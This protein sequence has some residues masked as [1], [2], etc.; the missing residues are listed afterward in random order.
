MSAMTSMK[1]KIVR[2]RVEEGKTGLFYATSPDLK[3]LLVAE[4]DIDT[5]DVAVSTAI[6]SLYEACGEKV[7]VTKAQDGDPQFFPWVAIPAEVAEKVM[8]PTRS[9][10]VS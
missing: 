5:L 7:V 4:A 3:G 8:A 9:R 10:V 6:V 2:V 1:A